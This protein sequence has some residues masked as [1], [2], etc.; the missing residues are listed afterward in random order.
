MHATRY[1]QPSIFAKNAY[2]QTNLQAGYIFVC[3]LGG[4]GG[5]TDATRSCMTHWHIITRMFH[6]FQD[7]CDVGYACAQ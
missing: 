7:I 5:D 4:G 1:S 2:N 6:L 3:V